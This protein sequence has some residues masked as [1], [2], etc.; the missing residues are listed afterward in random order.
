L[1][2]VTLHLRLINSFFDDVVE[3]ALRLQLASF[4]CFFV[5]KATEYRLMLSPAEIR[6]FLRLR[7]EHFGNL[8]VHASY[9]VN[10]ASAE[11]SCLHTLQ[12]EL[13]VAKRLE[14]THVV[15]HPGSTDAGAV[16]RHDG[17]DIVAKNLN[18]ILK[19]EQDITILLENTAH[20][21]FSIG[22]D[23]TDFALLLEKI[24]Q[25]EKI[26]FCLDT[27]HAYSFGYDLTRDVAQENFLLLAQRTLTQEKIALIHLNDTTELCGSKVD[28]HVAPG[29]GAI[30][31][32]A[33]RTFALNPLVVNVPIV[34][35]L[36]ILS[37]EEE[38]LVLNEVRDWRA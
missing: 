33:L 4:Q 22:G 8:Y 1:R 24:D 31:G 3:K 9:W 18:E 21:N 34:M 7:R 17:I 37:E 23:L 25:P 36:P 32:V 10:L 28:K 26:A 30:G 13:T 14:F 11:N 19:D 16:S 6:K 29:K 27:A 35:E 20:G 2:T 38:L 5:S 12:H 15:L